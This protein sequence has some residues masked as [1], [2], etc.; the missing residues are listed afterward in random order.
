[1]QPLTEFN[2]A[3]LPGIIELAKIV[4]AQF[5]AGQNMSRFLA[6][7]SV[8]RSEVDT[9]CRAFAITPGAVPCI[10]ATPEVAYLLHF[11]LL[12]GIEFAQFLQRSGFGNSERDPQDWLKFL[13]IDSWHGYLV[14][15]WRAAFSKMYGTST[16][17]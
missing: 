4:G 16:E 8:L 5:E 9:T 12:S 10:P 1:M 6:L 2:K 17:N 11:R 3:W 7:E 14:H 13:L 15:E